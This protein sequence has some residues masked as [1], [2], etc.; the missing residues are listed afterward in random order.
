MSKRIS[1]KRLALLG[2]LSAT[3]AGIFACG[4]GDGGRGRRVI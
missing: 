2:L 4:G 3:A 1:K